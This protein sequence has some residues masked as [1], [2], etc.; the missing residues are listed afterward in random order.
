M[1]HPFDHPSAE[2]LFTRVAQ[3]FS[4]R[5]TYLVTDRQLLFVCGGAID[6]PAKSLRKE[7]L[8][9]ASERLQGFRI[10]LAETAAKDVTHHAEPRFLNIAEFES[11]LADVA[12]CILIF[13]ETPGSL[14]ELGYFAALDRIR[15][16]CLVVNHFEFQ[17]QES[18]INNGPLAL[19]DSPD[20]VL[21]PTIHIDWH[22]LPPNL[23]LVCDRIRGRLGQ[24]RRKRI[25]PGQ[26][27]SLNGKGK[28]AVIEEII[29]RFKIIDIESLL[30]ALRRLFATIISDDQVRELV[31]ILISSGYIIR[32]TADRDFFSP[33]ADAYRLLSIDGVDTEGLSAAVIDF[34]QR[35]APWIYEVLVGAPE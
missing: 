31:S 20:S 25:D 7:F 6:D 10:F 11:L 22:A 5:H 33:S 14:T 27:D 16:K 26:F 23:E 19:F 18:F 12:D 15:R 9:V 3:A 13:P 2:G 21:R 35:R 24:T 30:I 1:S 17:G 32:T 28:L 29:Y 34:Y 8:R 4:S